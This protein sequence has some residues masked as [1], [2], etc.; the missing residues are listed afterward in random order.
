MVARVDAEVIRIGSW[1]RRSIASGSGPSGV[2]LTTAKR[3]RIRGSRTK[4]LMGPMSMTLTRDTAIHGVER[5]QVESAIS[6]PPTPRSSTE[7][8]MRREVLM[9]SQARAR[10]CS[11]SLARRRAERPNSQIPRLTQVPMAPLT[12]TNNAKG[13]RL[14]VAS[15]LS[16]SRLK[17][18]GPCGA[19]DCDTTASLDA[20]CRAWHANDC[21]DTIL[22][23]HN[24]A[25]CHRSSCFHHQPRCLEE[26]GGP[27]GVRRGSH[28]DLARFQASVV[29]IKDHPH[30]SRHDPRG[31]RGSTQCSFCLSSALRFLRLSGGFGSIRKQ[32]EWHMTTPKLP[33]E[34]G[35]SLTHFLPQIRSDQRC[36]YVGKGKKE[37][38]CGL[39]HPPGSGQFL[40]DRPEELACLCQEQ[41]YDKASHLAEA[42]QGMG[43]LQAQAH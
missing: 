9:I 36:V 14:I 11:T 31:R 33:R 13:Y 43:A 12:C 39:G 20:L 5:P 29:R 32:D 25:V 4:A 26:Q 30:E 23:S 22:A 37:D 40:S 27:T 41:P 24:R 42:C 35:S 1:V 17:G 15:S 2:S 18:N 19:I 7:S 21:R 8:T 34:S 38:I 3:E 28:Q 10:I 16:L 6:N